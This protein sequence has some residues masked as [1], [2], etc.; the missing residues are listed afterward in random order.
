M[1]AAM[2]AGAFGAFPAP[3][4]GAVSPPG[5]QGPL[6]PYHPAARAVGFLAAGAGTPPGPGAGTP[7]PFVANGSESL[8]WNSPMLGWSSP[9]YFIPVIGKRKNMLPVIGQARILAWK[10]PVVC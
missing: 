6:G 3:G 2:A 7:T 8:T 5:P 1:M 10:Q 4:P 9:C